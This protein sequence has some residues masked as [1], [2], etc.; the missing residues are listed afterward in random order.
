M[1]ST[2]GVKNIGAVYNNKNGT[3]FQYTD[4]GMCGQIILNVLQ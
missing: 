2:Y 4:A 3:G 1:E